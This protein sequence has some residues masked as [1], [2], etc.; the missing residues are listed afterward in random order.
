[1]D[2]N[3]K[4]GPRG[5]RN[6]NGQL[7]MNFSKVLGAVTAATL[8]RVQVLLFDER[9]TTREAKARL[10]LEKVRA[11]LDA[12]SAAC[13]LERYLEDSGVGAMPTVPCSYPPP[14]E[15]AFFDYDVVRAHIREQYYS[16]PLSPGRRE[17]L[18]MQHLK[19]GKTAR[20]VRRLFGPAMPA[21]NEEDDVDE[22][23]E[24]GEEVEDGEVEEEVAVAEGVADS[25]SPE[26]AT[27]TALLAHDAVAAV[28][29][30][31]ATNTDTDDAEESA[32]A[33]PL[34]AA[35]LE[36]LEYY[37]IKAAK[38]KRGTLKRLHKK[39]TAAATI[40]GEAEGED[41]DTSTAGT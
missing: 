40:T 18:I 14:P 27:R 2:S 16:D 7:C 22:E 12:M 38:R 35:D 17:A 36:L 24:D 9:Y 25:R 30:A 5:P 34:T 37:K 23:E 33:A 41:V 1:M 32:E 13:L 8:P 4:M 28:T 6:F 20:E 26:G 11:S 3:G 21:V 29:V 39:T 15:L 19:A 31:V 10:R